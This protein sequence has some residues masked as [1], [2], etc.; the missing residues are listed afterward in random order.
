MKTKNI[1]IVTKFW[2]DVTDI[3]HKL[4]NNESPLMLIQKLQIEIEAPS[5]AK[6]VP[7][8]CFATLE[9]LWHH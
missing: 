7:A 5:S 9:Q 1:R 6:G 3:C 4:Y 8:V 2:L